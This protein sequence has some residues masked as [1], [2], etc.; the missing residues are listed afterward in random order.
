ML[1]VKINDLH[2]VKMTARKRRFFILL[3]LPSNT[4]L[5]VCAE[6]SFV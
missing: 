2:P 6:Y 4:T 1:F 5:V 3:Q